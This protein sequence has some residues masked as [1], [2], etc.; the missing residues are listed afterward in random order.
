[1]TAGL[2]QC[3]HVRPELLG[4]S[5][6]YDDMFREMFRRWAPEVE[7]RVYD[8]TKG[9]YPDAT[10]ACDGYLTTGSAFS[11]NDD[12]LWVRALE[13]FVRKLFDEGR[14]FAGICFGH[15]MI[16]RAL[17]GTVE[18]SEG[19][20]GVGAKETHFTAPVSGLPPTVRLLVSH[21]EQIGAL[22]PDATILA[23]NAHCPA[24]VISVGPHFL[25]I[26]G[27]PEFSPEYARALML[28]RQDRIPA[29]AIDAAM[30]T[31]E[32]ALHQQEVAR[33]IL[34]HLAAREPERPATPG[35]AE[36]EA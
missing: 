28:T 20:W 32:L 8:V 5:G 11:V 36:G 19:G 33:W 21:R 26:Q 3:D 16:A 29:E 15:Q 13:T 30:P 1:M 35:P 34:D 22:P 2:L 10:G 7:L 18:D 25:G 31:F 9:E 6:D 27:H 14:R 17:G 23:G 4:I 12:V 24:S